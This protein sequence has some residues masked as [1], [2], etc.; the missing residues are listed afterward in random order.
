MRSW[1]PLY[2]KKGPK[3]TASSPLSTSRFYFLLRVF[4]LDRRQIDR[5]VTVAELLQFDAVA[6]RQTEHQVRQRCSIRIPH[7]AVA[8]DSQRL[9]A[10]NHDGHGEVAVHVAVAH[11]AAKDYGGAIEERRVAVRNR[12]ELL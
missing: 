3:P 4:L 5:G 8:A 6:I 1:S 10:H 7:V 2:K 11:A 9:A 12:F